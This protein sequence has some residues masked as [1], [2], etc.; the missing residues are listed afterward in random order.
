MAG[1]TERIKSGEFVRAVYL[2]ETEAANRRE[3]EN[4]MMDKLGE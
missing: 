4:G 2:S 1:H 3:L